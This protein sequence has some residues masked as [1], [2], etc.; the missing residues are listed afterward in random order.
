MNGAHKVTEYATFFHFRLDC[1]MIP[2]ERSADMQ[3]VRLVL[4]TGGLMLDL[5]VYTFG[6]YGRKS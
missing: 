4:S 2:S 3:Q 6:V 1:A 5:S